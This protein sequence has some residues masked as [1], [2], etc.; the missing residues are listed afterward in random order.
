MVVRFCRDAAKVDVKLAA[1]QDG[2]IDM[3]LGAYGFTAE[4]TR[5]QVIKEQPPVV[6][7]CRRRC[8]G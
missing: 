7:G 3:A 6:A 8:S 1:L 2:P 5:R 4:R